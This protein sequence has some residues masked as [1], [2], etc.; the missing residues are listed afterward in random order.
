V[1]ILWTILVLLFA[2]ALCVAIVIHFLAKM[3]LQPPRMT[4][5]KALYVLRRMSPGDLGLPFEPLAFDVPKTE[6][7]ESIRIAVWWIDAASR[8]EKTV[9][10]IHGYGDAKVG[11]LAWAPTWRELGYNCLLIDLRAH[12]ESGGTIT[13]AGVLERD[14]L[15]AV[16]NRVR[17]DRPSQTKQVVLFG[18]SLGGAVALACAARRTDIAAVVC[19]STFADYGGAAIAHGHLIG[20]PLPSLLP[21]VI[22]WAQSLAHASFAEVRPTT[23]LTQCDC[24]VMLI[25]GDAD[26][27]VPEEQV[28][29]LGKALIA[30]QNPL[31][32][33]SIVED[34]G[35]VLSLTHDPEEYR[36][37]LAAFVGRL[38]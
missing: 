5:G 10:L 36:A 15:D 9:L 24:P 34:A 27:F 12:G 2:A 19:D 25:H 37:K 21:W 6:R 4:D 18:I 13:A 38:P 29:E 26:L 11:A 20:T 33:H 1:S 32:D 23:T 35:H 30:R 14:D 17:I 7:S 8:S 22:R 28:L 31:D 3:L 16:I